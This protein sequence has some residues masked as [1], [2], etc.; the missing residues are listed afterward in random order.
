MSGFRRRTYTSG[1]FCV[2]AS[3]SALAL[4][5]DEGAHK[6]RTSTAG[7]TS[8]TAE[9]ARIPEDLR[10]MRNMA[11]SE[12]GD[13]F[14]VQPDISADPEGG[15]LISDRMEGRVMRV[16]DT[17]EIL[18]WQG[19]KG[20]GPGEYEQ[21][22]A[23]RR[24]DNQMYVFD[25]QG[26]V[27]VLS[28][29][30]DSVIA[31]VQLPLYMPA[32]VEAWRSGEFLIAARD[33]QDHSRQAVWLWKTNT[34]NVQPLFWTTESSPSANLAH[35]AGVTKL[36]KRNDEV[37]VVFSLVDSVYLFR[38]DDWSRRRSI[39]LRGS[40]RAISADAVPAMLNA[41]TGPAFLSTVDLVVDVHWTDRHGLVVSYQSIL[42]DSV[43][44]RRWHMLQIEPADSM[45]REFRDVP[46]VLTVLPH[47]G[48][49][50][51]QNPGSELPSQWTI[52][53]LP[54]TN[55][56]QAGC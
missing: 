27:T 37:A 30:S 54:C 1:V 19:R 35:T 26:R 4:A 2:I 44:T 50:V 42:N 24:L 49:V 14:L 20:Q 38:A 15:F 17:G 33:P 22:L 56:R 9:G 43:L 31:T 48:E 45:Q 5:C 8:P 53:R 10:I 23:V 13:I 28:E 39:G 18:W 40:F 47:R 11:L 52:A 21:P 46:R 12:G 55:R 36:A 16:S 34:E 7:F 6:T 29:E 41:R 25:F 51:F 3:F 32:D